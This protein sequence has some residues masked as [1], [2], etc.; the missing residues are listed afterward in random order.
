MLGEHRQ[1]PMGASAHYSKLQKFNC[2]PAQLGVPAQTRC[3]LS[4]FYRALPACCSFWRLPGQR[5]PGSFQHTASHS[6]SGLI[7]ASSGYSSLL[8][9]RMAD[10]RGHNRL[11]TIARHILGVPSGQTETTCPHCKICQVCRQLQPRADTPPSQPFSELCSSRLPGKAL[12][13]AFMPQPQKESP[14]KIESKFSPEVRDALQQ[15]KPVVALESTIIS[16]GMPYPQ[17]LQTALEVEAVVR[18]HGAVPATIAIIGGQPCIGCDKEQLEYIA[19][20]G[21]AVRKVSRRDM[22]LVVGNSLDGATTVSGTMLLAARA[23]IKVFVTGGIGGVHR[24]GHV[25]MDVSADLTE[26]GRTP[27]AVVC[28]GAKSVLDIPRTL[29]YLETQGVC[30][31]VYGADEFPAFFSQHSG[32]KAPCRVDTPQQAARMICAS[33]DL[34]LDTG[35]LIAVPIPAEYAAEGAVIQRAI[36]ESLAE[37]DQQGIA[38][39]EVCYAGP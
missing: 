39:A 11:A 34:H 36:E 6:A 19:Q 25:S 3:W 33:Y 26:L 8:H 9:A 38:G 7:K 31:A 28:A 23:G 37:A 14:S 35:M 22:P 2:I 5:L 16:H 18:Q 21:T 1:G 24:G 15:G 32:C 4:K 20:R 17:N 30:V 12:R 10:S 29:E 13:S 27:V